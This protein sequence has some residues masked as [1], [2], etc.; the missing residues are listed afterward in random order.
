MQF[1]YVFVETHAARPGLLRIGVSAS[2]P[3]VAARDAP[4]IRYVARFNDREAAMM[5]AHELLKRHLRDVDSRLYQVSVTAAIGAIESLDL[6]HGR[7][8]LDPQLDLGVQQSISEISALLRRRHQR[9][10]WFFRILGY[11]AV[12]LLLWHI[13]IGPF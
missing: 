9:M 2:M 12:G 10:E 7:V 13:L 8:Y 6:H 3:E 1:G 5:H 11:I 4:R